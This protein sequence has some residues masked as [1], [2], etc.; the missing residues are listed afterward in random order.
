MSQRAGRP[1]VARN[2]DR[3]ALHTLMIDRVSGV[4]DCPYNLPCSLDIGILCSGKGGRLGQTISYIDPLWIHDC[5]SKAFKGLGNYAYTLY[6]SPCS[7][8]TSGAH[9]NGINKDC[10]E[11]AVKILA[12]AFGLWRVQDLKSK[13]IEVR[14]NVL[15]RGAK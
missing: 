2:P 15:K 4:V 3:R 12:D 7:I 9:S 14:W 8:L 6:S 10:P 11:R 5:Y 1:N 13:A